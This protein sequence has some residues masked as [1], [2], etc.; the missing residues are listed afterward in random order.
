MNV[1][2]RPLD[3]SSDRELAQYQLFE[4]ACAAALF[5]GVESYSVEQTRARLAPNRFWDLGHWVAVTGD[6]RI[7][8][9]VGTFVPLNENLDA[10][11]VEMS[12]HPE[13]RGQGVATALVTEALIPAIR[14]TGRSLITGYGAIPAEG[15]P[16]DPQ[17]P[18]NRVARALGVDRKNVA[19]CRVLD[20]PLA[21]SLLDD[22]AAQAAEKLG[23]YRVISFDD[24]VPEEY[25]P[26][27]GALLRQLDLDDPDED[28]EH[29][30]PEYTP[31]RIRLAEQR[32]RD[33]GKRSLIAVAVAPDG[34]FAGNSVVEF[35]SGEGTTMGW[36]ENTLV[37]PEHRGHRLGLALKVAT[38]RR[39]AQEAPGLRSLVTW[40]SHVNP[41]M[42]AINE[43]L[44][45]RV[46][47]REIAY[48]GRPAL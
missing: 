8:G 11:H 19:V 12:V 37:M 1:T 34:T 26:A 21:E 42:I 27:Y 18:A 33:S 47:H 23:D 20:L 28:V 6:D 17:L 46:A 44:G 13:H 14:A 48:Q 31:E 4:E 40:N 39:L 9:Y 5:G 10:V 38:H 25:L 32:R 41:W 45:Y 36:Q 3:V 24:A 30:A 22:L 43:Q 7:V 29:E 16:D 35:H 2:V 15:D